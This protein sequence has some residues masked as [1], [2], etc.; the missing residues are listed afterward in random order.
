MAENVDRSDKVEGLIRK[1]QGGHRARSD[2]ETPLARKRERVQRLVH[3]GSSR[4][5]AQFEMREEPAGSASRVEPSQLSP[6]FRRHL[7]RN[8]PRDFLPHRDEPPVPV[9][10]PEESLVFARIHESG[11]G[12]RETGNEV[13]KASS[14]FSV[15]RFPH[16]QATHCQL[17]KRAA[18]A[19]RSRPETVHSTARARGALRVAS[20]SA[21]EAGYTTAKKRGKIGRA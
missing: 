10:G 14:S 15:F 7:P 21:K 5:P 20:A 13:T 19:S 6:P 2:G 8:S 3:A 1:R 12:K 4:L 18:H 11:N 9:F 16:P 17:T